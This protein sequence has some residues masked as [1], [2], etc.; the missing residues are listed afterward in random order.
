[1]TKF[2]LIVLYTFD[3]IKVRESY[4]LYFEFLLYSISSVLRELGS[5]S[6]LNLKI[7]IYSQNVNLLEKEIRLNPQ[8]KTEI[9]SFYTIDSKKY[10]FDT[11]LV[12]LS[13]SIVKQFESFTCHARFFILKEL[14]ENNSDYNILYMDDDVCITHGFGDKIMAELPKIN[15]CL[16]SNV[17]TNNLILEWFVSDYQRLTQN[18]SLDIDFKIRSNFC[19]MIAMKHENK[20]Y[21]KQYYKKVLNNGI[22]YCPASNSDAK[23]LTLQMLCECIELYRDLHTIFSPFI[24]NDQLAVSIIYNKYHQTATINDNVNLCGIYHFYYEKY[25]FP[26]EIRKIFAIIYQYRLTNKVIDSIALAKME[27]HIKII[28]KQFKQFRYLFSPISSS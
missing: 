21:D 19:A 28:E 15:E 22:M 17:E 11:N 9:I 12:S 24:Y 14:L 1:M 8:F 20:E 16:T 6:D 10:F 5:R 3:L 4:N 26:N 13:N 27:P 25:S 7:Y 18:Y 2:N 23:S